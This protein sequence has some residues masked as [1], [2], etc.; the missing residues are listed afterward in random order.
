MRSQSLAIDI[1]ADELYNLLSFDDNYKEAVHRIKTD[2]PSITDADALKVLQLISIIS[3]DKKVDKI[4]IVA[5]TPVSFKTKVRK[6]KPVIE[7]LIS[8]SE[9]TILFTG[10][11]ISDYFKAM[12]EKINL[13][14][15]QGV[16][17]EF[18]VNDYNK[19]Q[20]ILSSIEHK[21]R[22]F[23]KVYEYSGKED[24]KMAALHA[25][26]IIVDKTKILISSSN[27]T[28][29]GL[30]GNIEIGVLVTSSKKVEQLYNIFSELKRQKVFTLVE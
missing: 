14:S 12:L 9:Q 2:I 24:D 6:T 20:P 15:K 11:S 23:L 27:L 26:I 22:H 13:K 25:K 18:F 3:K 16:V 30:D 8:A 19:F 4:E 29:H 10:Y 28:Y 17:I 7:E 1:L 5:T 21:K